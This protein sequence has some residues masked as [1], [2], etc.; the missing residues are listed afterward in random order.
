MLDQYFKSTL[1]K[2]RLVAM[3]EGI[4][5]LLL[6]FVAMPLK[7]LA[8]I[9]L[10]VKYVGWL[11]GGLFVLFMLWLLQIWL[12]YEWKFSKVIFAFVMSI[13]PFGTFYLEKKLKEEDK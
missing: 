13:V 2:F 11:H 5:Y 6:L 10:A 9:P 7:Y 8:D 12:E 1:G 3:L 4:S